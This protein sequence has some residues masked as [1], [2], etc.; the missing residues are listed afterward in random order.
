MNV[1]LLKLQA[2][3]EL[4]SSCRNEPQTTRELLALLGLFS[5]L[6]MSTVEFWI[7][8]LC[9]SSGILNTRKHK[10]SKTGSASVL[11]QGRETP[12]QFGHLERTNLNPWTLSG[13]GEAHTLLGSLERANR[14]HWTFLRDPTV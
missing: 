6:N 7:S 10:D 3:L 2:S 8:G 1:S 5:I 11:R 13:E 4:S 14:N 9:P 12:T